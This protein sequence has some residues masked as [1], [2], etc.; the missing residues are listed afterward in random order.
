VR[1]ELVRLGKVD[2]RETQELGLGVSV[3]ALRVTHPELLLLLL[4]LDE[5]LL[6]VLERGVVPLEV[7][8]NEPER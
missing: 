4:E 8:H 5:L 1:E 7:A 3:R 6:L 2:P